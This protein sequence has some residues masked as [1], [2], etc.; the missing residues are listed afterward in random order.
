MKRGKHRARDAIV[1]QD[2]SPWTLFI[3][4]TTTVPTKPHRYIEKTIVLIACVMLIR[5]LEGPVVQF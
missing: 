3:S 2:V 4:L 1:L 5:A